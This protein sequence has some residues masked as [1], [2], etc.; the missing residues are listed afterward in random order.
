MLTAFAFASSTAMACPDLAGNYTCVSQ[1]GDSVQ[2]PV[3]QAEV[4]G[5]TVYNWNG[6]EMITD[7]T[8]RPIPDT[9]YSKNQI[10]KAWCGTDDNLVANLKAQAYDSANHNFIGDADLTVDIRPDG[11]TGLV[12]TYNGTLTRP[13]NGGVYPIQMKVNCTRN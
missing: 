3:Q 9:V 10:L 2:I 8:P 1:Y 4:N 11:G 5:V 12:E 7:A 6:V 13:N